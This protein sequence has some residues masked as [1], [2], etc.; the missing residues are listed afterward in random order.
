MNLPMSETEWD[1]NVA[2]ST[3]LIFETRDLV[4]SVQKLL[5]SFDTYCFLVY[6]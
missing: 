6:F 4:F 2:W 1:W 5:C 3:N